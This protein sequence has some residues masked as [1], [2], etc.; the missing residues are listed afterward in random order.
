MDNNLT[1][2][3]FS[4]SQHFYIC[5]D[6]TRSGSGKQLT[7]VAG[8]SIF[9]FRT[10]KSPITRALSSGFSLSGE[11]LFGVLIGTEERCFDRYI[12]IYIYNNM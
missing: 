4:I 12:Y 11:N 9:M 6:V 7:M 1:E 2:F 10:I 8:V 3:T 5:Q